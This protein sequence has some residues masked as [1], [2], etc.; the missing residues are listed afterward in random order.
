MMITND[1]IH[2]DVDRCRRILDNILTEVDRKKVPRK[3]VQ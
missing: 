1:F 3:L 2:N